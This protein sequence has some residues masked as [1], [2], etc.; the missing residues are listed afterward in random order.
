MQ[1]TI[2]KRLPNTVQRKQFKE[3]EINEKENF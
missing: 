3:E 1:E 2:T